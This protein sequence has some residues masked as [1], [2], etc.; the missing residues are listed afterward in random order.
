MRFGIIAFLLALSLFPAIT[1]AQGVPGISDPMTVSLFPENPRPNDTVTVTV[2]SFSVDL[3]ATLITWTVNGKKITSAVGQKSFSLNAG[4]LGSIS[5]V[6]VSATAP[7]ISVA[8]SVVIRPADVSLLWEADTYT[9]PFYRGKA[10]HSYNGAFRITAIPELV[11][12]NGKMLDSKDLIYTWKKNGTVAGEASGYGKNQ[13]VSSQTSYL[14][15]GEDVTVEVSA[16]RDNVVASRSITIKPI[17]PKVLFYEKSGLYG[18]LYNKALGSRFALA[19]DEVTISAEPYFFSVPSKSAQNL[20]IFWKLNNASV[21]AFAGESDI[22]LRRD[23]NDAGR[24]SLEAV[25]QNTNKVLQGAKGT[26]L[27]TFDEKNP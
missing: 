6:D 10:L 20:S 18:M 1:M 22:T 15:E 14:R 11:G 23:S 2:Q 5:R 19:N 8:K 4:T 21:P 17:V 25:L 7:G 24:S 13:F 16:P 3:D 26:L 27:I 9:P 12:S